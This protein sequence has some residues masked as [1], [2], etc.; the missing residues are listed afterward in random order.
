MGFSARSC[1]GT[2]EWFIIPA[3]YTNDKQSRLADA[4]SPVINP[5]KPKLTTLG[6]NQTK[7]NQAALKR[8][9]DQS[10]VQ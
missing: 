10:A 8:T 3:N 2:A 7:L 9:V 4:G 1:F 5:M 6:G